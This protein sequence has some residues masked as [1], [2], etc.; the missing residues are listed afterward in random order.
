MVTFFD[1]SRVSTLFVSL[2]I[3]FAYGSRKGLVSS[4]H[5]KQQFDFVS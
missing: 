2:Y 1:D 5:N 3:S 4:I